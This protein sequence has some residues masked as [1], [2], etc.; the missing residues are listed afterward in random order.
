MPS[1]TYRQHLP[2]DL[3]EN[4]EFPTVFSGFAGRNPSEMRFVLEGE[5]EQTV[6]AVKF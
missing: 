6:T 2:L 5:F 4:F 1:I 3:L